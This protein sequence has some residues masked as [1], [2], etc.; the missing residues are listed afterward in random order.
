M[1]DGWDRKLEPTL[2]WAQKALTE[3]TLAG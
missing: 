3:E 1:D 2:Q